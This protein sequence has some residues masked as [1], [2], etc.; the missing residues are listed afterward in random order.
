MTKTLTFYAWALNSQGKIEQTK[1]VR[2]MAGPG[3]CVSK[4]Q[5][6]TGVLYKSNKAAAADVARLNG[7]K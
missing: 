3:V 7:C 5:T 6:F 1:I 2:E 4:S